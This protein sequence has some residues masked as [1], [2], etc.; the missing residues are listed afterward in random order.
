MSLE[1]PKTIDSIIFLSFIF[2]SKKQGGGG[3]DNWQPLHKF[4]YLAK[5][6]METGL[7]GDWLKLVG[8]PA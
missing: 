4:M 1:H 7:C 3:G 8:S 5:I 2:F 6:F